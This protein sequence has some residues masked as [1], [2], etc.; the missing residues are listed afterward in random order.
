MIKQETVLKDFLKIAEDTKLPH[1][2]A[3]HNVLHVIVNSIILCEKFKLSVKSVFTV[4]FS[5]HPKKKCVGVAN[6]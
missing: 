6:W 5:E 4:E 3:G 2:C 1:Q